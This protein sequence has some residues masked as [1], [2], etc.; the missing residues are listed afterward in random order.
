MSSSDPQSLV[1]LMDDLQLVYGG[2]PATNPRLATVIATAKK[3]T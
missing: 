2:D 1:K 3:G